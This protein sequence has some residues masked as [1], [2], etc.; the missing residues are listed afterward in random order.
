MAF[1]RIFFSFSFSCLSE[2][3]AYKFT[4]EKI[5]ACYLFFPSERGEVVSRVKQYWPVGVVIYR[6]LSIVPE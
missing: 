3:G 4:S 2:E 6:G 1:V 5:A